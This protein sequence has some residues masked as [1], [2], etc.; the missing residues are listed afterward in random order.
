MSVF[1]K[2]NIQVLK[3]RTIFRMLIYL[4]VLLADD[5]RVRLVLWCLSQLSTIF[6]LYLGGQLYNFVGIMYGR[7]CTKCKYFVRSVLFV[8]ETGVLGEN[9]RPVASH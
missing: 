7:S 2:S 9:R 4:I 5:R 3:L 1:N 8:E 6:H